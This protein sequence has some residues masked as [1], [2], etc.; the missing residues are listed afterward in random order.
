MNEPIEKQRSFGLKVIKHSPL[1]VVI[2]GL[3]ILIGQIYFSFKIS[4]LISTIV[5]GMFL[6]PFIVKHYRTN[7]SLYI[8]LY[9]FAFVIGLFI[10]YSFSKSNESIEF[11]GVFTGLGILFGNAIVFATLRK[12]LL[13]YIEKGNW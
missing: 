6:S 5:L 13:N 3:V 11:V 7:E 8:N 10:I 2:I 9:A 12:R 1:G 4:Y